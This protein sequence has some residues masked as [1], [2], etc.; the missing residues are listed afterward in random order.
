[1]ND[2]FIQTDKKRNINDTLIHGCDTLD[3]ALHVKKKEQIK[4]STSRQRYNNGKQ[5][6]INLF[7]KL[8]HHGLRDV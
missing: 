4:P 7:L 8:L 5:L 6:R 2:I 3:P 1:M